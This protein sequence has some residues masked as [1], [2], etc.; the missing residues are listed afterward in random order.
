MT[1]GKHFYC[2]GRPD[3][4]RRL[5]R[6]KKF[7]VLFSLYTLYMVPYF[8]VEPTLKIACT[9][10]AVHVCFSYFGLQLY[11]H[12]YHYCK[13]LEETSSLFSIDPEAME[14]FSSISVCS[15][16][17]ESVSAIQP[18][19]MALLSQS[20]S[21]TLVGLETD[22]SLDRHSG[23]YELQHIS[24]D[25]CDDDET[26]D[27]DGDDSTDV[28]DDYRD[29]DTIADGSYSDDESDDDIRDYDDPDIV[30]PTQSRRVLRHSSVR[31]VRPL[32]RPSDLADK[33]KLLMDDKS[34]NTSTFMHA[35]VQGGMTHPMSTL[36]Y[37]TQTWRRVS[38]DRTPSR[39]ADCSSTPSLQGGQ[40]HPDIGCCT[41]PPSPAHS[42]LATVHDKEPG[43]RSSF[44]LG[45]KTNDKL[46]RKLWAE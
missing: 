38:M 27:C 35:D 1:I 45:K 34:T 30:L 3:T 29:R 28:N 2:L 23:D 19:G 7:E 32:R 43:I 16:T 37:I 33:V 10:M 9:S 6:H 14:T 24:F 26:G 42:L 11:R 22:F 4:T 40:E 8:V 39:L 46:W 41:E 21:D 25:D 5:Y 44:M 12:L 17:A 15:F 20:S 31:E 36:N 18:P 13:C